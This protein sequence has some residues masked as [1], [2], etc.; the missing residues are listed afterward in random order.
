MNKGIAISMIL[1]LIV[2][3]LVAGVTVYYT[4]R[5]LSGSTLSEHECRGMM[6]SWCMGCGN[7]NWEGGT[8]MDSALSECATAHWG[9][10]HTDCDAEDDCNAFLPGGW[11]GTGTTLAPETCAS[12]EGGYCDSVA[13]C[14]AAGGI[15]AASKWECAWCCC[16][17]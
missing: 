13:N 11:G 17:V 5:S 1:L 12:E 4:Y 2:G 15:C 6:I 14:G 10:S 3:V 7:L 8:G 16:V 9:I